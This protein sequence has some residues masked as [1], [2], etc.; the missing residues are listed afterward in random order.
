MV[1]EY[2]CSR[3][4]SR[5]QSANLYYK[6]YSAIL[7]GFYLPVYES[8]RYFDQGAQIYRL[9]HQLPLPTWDRVSNPSIISPHFLTAILDDF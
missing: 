5:S 4:G 3:I 7:I 2:L 1:A 9:T 6:L 8:D